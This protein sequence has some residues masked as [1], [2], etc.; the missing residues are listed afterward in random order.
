[1]GIILAHE[2]GHSVGLVAP[3]ASP[4]GL[5]GDSSLHNTFAGATD[6]MAPSVGYEAMITLDYRFRDLDIAYLRHK[7][8]LR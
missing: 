3:G 1:M 6:V 2:V 7:V 4:G 8:L 5:Y